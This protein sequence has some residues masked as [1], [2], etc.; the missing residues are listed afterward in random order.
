LLQI[1]W[2]KRDIRLQ[3][4]AP[5]A[6]AIA[7]GFPVML[8][9]VFE[10]SMVRA[11]DYDVRHARFVWQSLQ[12]VQKQLAG[13]TQILIVNGEVTDVLQAICMQQPVQS[14][15]SHTET[16]N[17]ISYTRDKAVARWCR[18]RAITWLQWGDRAI[19]RGLRQRDN[20]PKQWYTYM[21]E[22]QAV[23]NISK[24]N[25][26]SLPAFSNT[27]HAFTDLFPGEAEKH[28][29]MQPGGSSKG[30]MYLNS[31]LQDRCINYQKQISKPE[32]SRT[33]C[34]RLSPYLAY[35]CLSIRQ[36]YQAT[37]EQIELI[38]QRKRPLTAFLDRLRWH[39]HFIQKLE[40]RPE[41]EWE[42]TNPGFK[43][44]RNITDNGLLHAWMQGETGYPLVDASMRCLKETGYINFRMWAMLVSFLTH[45]LWQPW[46]SGVHH[47][48]RYFLDYEPGIH[49]PQFQMQAGV[50]G[51]NTIR[52]YNPVKQAQDHDPKGIFVKK[53]IPVLAK[54][55]IPLLNQP[56]LMTQMEQQSYGCMLGS[57][58]P[59]PIIDLAQASE[60]ARKQLWQ[61][62]NNPE[63]KKH[64]AA[65]LSGLSGR[66]TE[67][68]EGM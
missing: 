60:H 62:K 32:G 27:I 50:T 58:Y 13:H 19:V 43:D 61:R 28:T 46:Q 20:W 8:L 47:L 38:P 15:Y 1:V 26:A 23:I 21:H 5:L 16:G 52:I 3:D 51:I 66:K 48:A 55:P 63:V 10:P 17:A 41:L 18:Q 14:L 11:T 53:W 6:A 57:D 64:N 4:H 65:I 49:Y 22:T 54:V 37:K 2:L 44:L 36:V 34:S 35:G 7:T 25:A 30:W 42:N 9:Y 33:G 45:H 24:L 59:A 56:W 40:S 29:A 68:Q 12:D 67:H 31:F 39:S